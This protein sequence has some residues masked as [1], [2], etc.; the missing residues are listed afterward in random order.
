MFYIDLFQSD[1]KATSATNRTGIFS[2]KR[3]LNQ[4]FHLATWEFIQSLNW[5]FFCFSWIKTLATKI[6]VAIIKVG[7]ESYFFHSKFSIYDDATTNGRSD[8]RSVF[9]W[10][11]FYNLVGSLVGVH[12]S[13]HIFWIW[14]MHLRLFRHEKIM[15]HP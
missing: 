15:S 14:L 7:G 13:W 5:I 2:R 10:K 4:I 8:I 3:H 1:K 11:I 6:L 12:F 9:K